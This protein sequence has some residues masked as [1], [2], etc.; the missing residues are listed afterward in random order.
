MKV[1]PQLVTKFKEE[2]T[3]YPNKKYVK[4]DVI[5][6]DNKTFETDI[7]KDEV[8]LVKYLKF[9]VFPKLTE[10]QRTKLLEKIEAYGDEKW[11]EG[12]FS[13]TYEG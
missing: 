9:H 7:P 1:D 3:H 12:G 5:G 6:S 10:R 2:V 13:A 8:E 11:E 4:V